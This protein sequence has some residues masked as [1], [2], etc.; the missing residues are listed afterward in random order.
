MEVQIVLAIEDA[1]LRKR[2]LLACKEAHRGVAGHAP[3]ILVRDSL[4]EAIIASCEIVKESSSTGALLVSD[5]LASE[6]T[7]EPLR[8]KD[9][10]FDRLSQL[11]IATVAIS[12][13]TPTGSVS[14]CVVVG[15]GVEHD[16]CVAL[17]RKLIDKVVF[18]LPPKRSTSRVMLNDP[19]PNRLTQ[20]D[21]FRESLQL[22]HDVYDT[23]GYLTEDYYATGSTLEINWCDGHS[24]HYGIYAETEGGGRELASTARAILSGAPPESSS[25]W[26]NTVVG[27][28][29][30]LRNYISKQQLAL[31]AFR[32]PA[33]EAL[34]L[35]EEMKDAF[36]SESWAELSRV[37]V[38]PAY[39]GLGLS[40]KMIGFVLQDLTQ[41]GMQGVVLE[42]LEIHKPIYEEFN[43]ASL[44]QEGASFGITK[45]M[46]GMVTELP[47]GTMSSRFEMEK[48]V[49]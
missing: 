6:W 31:A 4:K 44:D 19:E 13:D 33:F 43:F 15:T 49:K 21:E 20:L 37:I 10:P 41:R 48:V 24:L 7:Q 11:P 14:E 35:Y 18:L 2:W 26:V 1:S 34:V 25:D 47:A 40:K 3:T 46:V 42:C 22:R 36:E 8:E 45:T 38:H 9:M 17:I 12:S 5:C 29:A 23:M 39:R 32:L 30:L 27:P 16:D 28:D